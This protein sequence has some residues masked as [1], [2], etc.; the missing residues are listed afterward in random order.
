MTITTLIH[1]I[2]DERDKFVE[3]HNS[4]IGTSELAIICGLSP[5]KT[6]FQLWCEKTGKVK[7]EF[8]ENDFTW[9]GTKMESIIAELFERRTNLKL[10]EANHTKLNDKYPFIVVSPDRYVIESDGTIGNV[11][12]KNT[13]AFNRHLWLDNQ[14]PDAAHC[15]ALAA[16]GLL[17]LNS[18]YYICGLVGGSPRDFFY[19]RFPFDKGVFEQLM[20]KAAAFAE[21]IEK[22]IPPPVGARDTDAVF[23]YLGEPDLDK[24]IRLP[25]SSH[26]LFLRYDKLKAEKKGI[27]QRVKELDEE[28]DAI[29]N[30]LHLTLGHAQFGEL[31]DRLVAVKEWRR[32]AYSVDEKSGFRVIIK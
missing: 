10:L 26:E 23:D 13:S 21:M 25:D 8:V 5:Y 12:I 27:S 20:E 28:I 30:S 14:A 4:K 6:A 18:Y 11:E 31:G 2:T 16:N 22:D 17:E 15:Q 9:L 32:K 1:N 7:K 29:E 24:K 19:P 3:L